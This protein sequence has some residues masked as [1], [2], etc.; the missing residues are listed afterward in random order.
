MADD[1]PK[2]M[3]RDEVLTLKVGEIVIV[4]VD[5]MGEDG[6]DVERTH[7]AGTEARVLGIRSLP[8][9]QGL[10]VT[11]EVGEAENERIVSVFDESDECGYAFVRPV[12]QEFIAE[13]RMESAGAELMALS[14]RLEKHPEFAVDV[15][16][17][18][19]I[20]GWLSIGRIDDMHFAFL[21]VLGGMLNAMRRRNFAFA[22]DRS[23]S[24]QFEEFLNTIP[25]PLPGE[26]GFIDQATLDPKE[27]RDAFD[28]VIEVGE[29][30]RWTT[31][32]GIER[33]LARDVTVKPD[34]LHGTA[35]VYAEGDEVPLLA[36]GATVR[37]RNGGGALR[38]IDEGDM[39]RTARETPPEELSRGA[40]TLL[41]AVPFDKETA[42]IVAKGLDLFLSEAHLQS[43]YEANAVEKA[44]SIRDALDMVAR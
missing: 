8:A 20:S 42:A 11:I 30:R 25:D 26:I 24:G 27:R 7:P 22:E 28:A 23:I 9:P 10:A 32:D 44:T 12:D 21:K 36:D 13:P 14:F 15:T 38:I 16:R 37:I 34:G 5:C 33:A 39:G 35:D 43:R 41:R 1:A 31:H 29:I 6:D 2:T 3:T 4:Q 19:Q 18:R 40:A 17:L